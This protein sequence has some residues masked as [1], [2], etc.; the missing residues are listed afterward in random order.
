MKFKNEDRLGMDVRALLNL[1]VAASAGRVAVQAREL[2]AVAP[3]D[4]G[5]NLDQYLNKTPGGFVMANRPDAITPTA[6]RMEL[7]QSSE[8]SDEK[9][10]FGI[11][12]S[13]GWGDGGEE[14]IFRNGAPIWYSPVFRTEDLITTFSEV[15]KNPKP[16]H[17]TDKAATPYSSMQAADLA[18]N[19]NP[20]L[21]DIALG[22]WNEPKFHSATKREIAGEIN[23]RIL[24][25]WSLE[26]IIS[27]I[28]LPLEHKRR[29]G[30]YDM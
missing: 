15:F 3:P 20:E 24:S 22:I 5:V 23:A 30:R 6:G 14:A 17:L 10:F 29:R 16:G 4:D 28:E 19:T 26:A 7:V 18:P 25:N 2:V 11:G 13:L 12:K 9:V 8:F 1:K 27:R 21:Q